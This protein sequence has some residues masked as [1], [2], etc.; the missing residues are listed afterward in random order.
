MWNSYFLIPSREIAPR[1]EKI[2]NKQ[3]IKLDRSTATTWKCCWEREENE[4]NG[5]VLSLSIRSD[6]P[7]S[8]IATRKL[9]FESFWKIEFVWLTFTTINQVE[10]NENLGER[11]TISDF[12]LPSKIFLFQ[13]IEAL[14]E[15]TSAD[16][17]VELVYAISYLIYRGQKRKR[18]KE[19]GR[20]RQSTVRSFKALSQYKVF[21]LFCF[22][23]H[24]LY[25]SSPHNMRNERKFIMFSSS[26]VGNYFQLIKRT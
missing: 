19:W 9:P 11:K 2:G 7:L 20:G 3:R 25:F 21:L 13:S 6:S 12:R 24:F 10:P 5:I 17:C 22:H 1:G 26:V 4:R 23:S 8:F 15:T 18:S 16:C 14:A